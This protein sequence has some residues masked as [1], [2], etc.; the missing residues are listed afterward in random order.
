MV[1]GESLADHVSDLAV[2]LI[3]AVVGCVL[4]IRGFSWE[5]RRG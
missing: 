3:W 2:V 5:A 1:T 4:A